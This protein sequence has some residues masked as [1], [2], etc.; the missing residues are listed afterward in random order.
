MKNILLFVLLSLAYTTMAQKP[1]MTH[2]RMWLLKKIGTPALSPSGK[3]V[4]FSRTETSYT[5]EE[6]T[7]DLWLAPADGSSE[8]RKITN[9]KGGEE[10]YFCRVWTCNGAT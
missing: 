3:W 2:E 7:T 1:A 6:Q 9:T 5:T 8:P 4:V 10:G